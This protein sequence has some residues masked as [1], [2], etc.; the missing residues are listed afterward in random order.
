MSGSDTTRPLTEMEHQLASWMLEHGVPEALA[1]LHQL[2]EAE[3]SSWRCPCGCAS[4]NFLIKGQPKPRAGIRVLGDFVFGEG[5]RESG[6]FIFESDGVLG[7]IEVYGFGDD[8]PKILP[9]IT[10]LRVWGPGTQPN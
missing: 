8:A 5:E 4:I 6:A 1:F 3:V 9:A 2:E 10:E 7:G